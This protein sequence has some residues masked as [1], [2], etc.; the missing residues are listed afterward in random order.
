M[1]VA[2]LVPV[3]ETVAACDTVWEGVAEP[4]C[5]GVGL[6]ADLT[7][8]TPKL[9]YVAESLVHDAPLLELTSAPT[10]CANA[11]VGTWL[12]V[13]SSTSCHETALLA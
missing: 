9:A 2:L 5:V 12:T 6:H 8:R 3:C 13:P 4:V 1:A 10:A 11:P 7:A